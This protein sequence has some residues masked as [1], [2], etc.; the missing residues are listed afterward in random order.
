MVLADRYRLD[1][2]LG[3]GGTGEVWAAWD[4]RLARP[5][6]VKMPAARAADDAEARF[7]REAR[8]EAHLHHPHIVEVYDFGVQDGRSYLVMQLAGDRTLADELKAYGPRPAHWVADKA[9]QIADGLAEAHRLGIVHRDIKPSNILLDG[10]GSVKIADFGIARGLG[11]DTV[12]EVTVTGMVTGTSAYM[13][14]EAA[15]GNVLGPA[16]DVYSL[17]C[18]LYQ[19]LAGR[20]PFLAEHP[21]GM[22]HQHVERLP[23][24]LRAVRP[25]VPEALEAFVAGMLAKD[26]RDRPTALEVRDWF[27]DGAWRAGAPT[28]LAFPGPASGTRAFAPAGHAFA[29]GPVP[30]TAPV[31]V[32]GRRAALPAA[33]GAGAGVAAVAVAVLA[34]AWPIGEAHS[35][36]QPSDVRPAPQAAASQHVTTPGPR[37]APTRHAFVPGVNSQPVNDW[38]TSPPTPRGTDGAADV[39][40][41]PATPGPRND[42]QPVGA[43]S[44]A[45]GSTPGDLATTA[46]QPSPAAPSPTDSPQ[47]TATP[48]DTPS[49]TVSPSAT[50]DAGGDGAA[51]GRKK[52]PQH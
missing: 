25:G 48:T 36:P 40:H 18:T 17:G 28:R 49:T 34:L 26:P 41:T 13:S 14:P 43:P 45:T 21:L 37:I 47:P 33:A 11:G 5:V 29:P 24:P 7:R 22:L 8:T 50:T 2:L 19:L 20:P 6:A 32:H 35:S 31:P 30:A 23:P 4:L 1:R 42:K 38:Q 15:R 27:R 16:A 10:A 52:P 51:A 12:T 39:R 46:P 3:Q 9:A 44:P